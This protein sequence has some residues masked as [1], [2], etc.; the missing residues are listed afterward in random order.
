LRSTLRNTDIDDVIILCIK[1][2][3]Y[4]YY[5]NGLSG[6]HNPVANPTLSAV[7]LYALA[8]IRWPSKSVMDRVKIKLRVAGHKIV[9]LN[10]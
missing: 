2:T 7:Q 8:N 9:A 1:V 5:D 6:K 4:L 3:E 10:F